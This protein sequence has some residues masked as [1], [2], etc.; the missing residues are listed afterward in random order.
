M[1]KIITL[2]L[3]LSLLFLTAFKISASESNNYS[4]ADDIKVYYQGNLMQFDTPPVIVEGRT[5]V[6]MRKTFESFGATVDWIDTTKTVNA[7][8]FGVDLSLSIDNYL[9]F[10]NAN[11]IELEV[12]PLLISGYTYVPLRVVSETMFHDILWDEANRTISITPNNKCGI[13]FYDDGITIKYAGGLINGE[14][15]GYGTTY[16]IDGQRESVGYYTDSVLN[17]SGILFTD[18]FSYV[19]NFTN[20]DINGEGSIYNLKNNQS[21]DGVFNYNVF[22]YSNVELYDNG[23]LIYRGGFSPD[24][25]RNGNGMM[26]GDDELVYVGNFIN[27]VF[28]GPFDIYYSNGDYCTSEIYIMGTDIKNYKTNLYY[29]CIGLLN[30]WATKQYEYLN[31]LIYSDPYTSDM[32]KEIYKQYGINIDEDGNVVNSEDDSFSQANA[33]RWN[34]YYISQANEAILNAHNAKI[35]ACQANITSFV[36][37]MTNILNDELQILSDI[38]YY[39][40]VKSNNAL[41]IE[42]LKKELTQNSEF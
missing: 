10:V 8:Y 27:D 13:L 29:E 30:D 19:G 7:S 33:N 35:N 40:K 15:N 20:G 22:D 4:Y 41:T 25:K 32:A 38:E 3:L 31:E 12:P 16:K 23:Q 26:Y 11:F 42:K 37:N 34:A 6:P 24:W 2:S 9:C 5:L 39:N 17:G 36:N 28:D 18:N 1:K 14:K 21:I